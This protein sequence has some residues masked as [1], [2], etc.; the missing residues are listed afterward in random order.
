MN[1]IVTV[2]RYGEVKVTL[3]SWKED[4]AQTFVL[5]NTTGGIVAFPASEWAKV[6][7]KLRASIEILAQMALEEYDERS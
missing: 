6:P 4:G 5:G 1:V 2:N 7:F 3:S